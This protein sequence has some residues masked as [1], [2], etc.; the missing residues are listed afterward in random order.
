ML[1][2]LQIKDFAII[3]AVELEL[4]AGLTALTGETG[5][6]KSIL[7]DAVLAAVGGRAGAELIREGAERAEISLSF[8]IAANAPAREWLLEQDI[9]V[10]DELILRRVISR[11]G[12]SRHQVNGQTVTAQ[13]ARALGATLIDIHGQAEFLSL[14]KRDRQRALLDAFGRHEALAAPV[15]ASAREW[16]SLGERLRAVQSAGAEREARRDYLSYQVRELEALA[17]RDGELESLTQ[18]AN[19]LAHRGRLLAAAREALGLLYEGEEHDAHALAGRADAALKAVVELDPA[20]AS[21]RAALAEALIGLQEAGR[22]L[23]AYLEGLEIDEARQNEVERRMA[24][25]EELAR[26]HR[27]KVAELGGLLER[28]RGEL[29]ELEGAAGSAE[30]L[31]A[32]LQGVAAEYQ[33]ASAKLSQAR[34]KAAKAL[35]KAVTEHMRGLGMP[36][37]RFAIELAAARDEPRVQGAEDVEFKVAANPGQT[38]MPVAKVAS[39]GELSRIS[40]SLEV[41]SRDAADT[42]PAMIFDEVDAGV[43]G[44]VAAMVG[45]ELKALGQR[46]QVLCVTHL[47]QVAAQADH[48]VQVEKTTDGKRTRTSL[49]ALKTPER[50]EELARML[51]GAGPS[52]TARD[53]ARALLA[54]RG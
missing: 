33:A 49:K 23:A 29:A 51:G 47:P 35:G 28:Y 2:F 22:G 26:K 16:R 32:H 25:I 19:R 40:L 44:A 45:R 46:A 39:G 21:T 36:G 42:L 10:E 15:A 54:G 27:V 6:G 38:P 31:A 34:G 53:H 18:E 50:I 17:L 1:R 24:A 20:L 5:A 13:L 30:A 14:L 4:E 41:A 11:D 9:P 37:G 12:R 3:D 48:H 43:G 7:V 8:D 52:A